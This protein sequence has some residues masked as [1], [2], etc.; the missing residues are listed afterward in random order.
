MREKLLRQLRLRFR[1]RL[2]WGD[3]NA[4]HLLHV[5]RGP[6]LQGVPLG[7]HEVGSER[8]IQEVQVLDD[9]V[10]AERSAEDVGRIGNLQLGDVGNGRVNW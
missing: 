5:L 2:P 10:L 9:G 7:E 6:D 3:C 8:W 1:R 4:L